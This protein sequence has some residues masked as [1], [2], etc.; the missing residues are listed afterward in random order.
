MRNIEL[1]WLGRAIS[2]CFTKVSP[3]VISINA[4]DFLALIR[5]RGGIHKHFAGHRAGE[6]GG[7]TAPLK[8]KGNKQRKKN[9]SMPTPILYQSLNI[10]AWA[11]HETE[12]ARPV[13]ALQLL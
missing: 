7:G 8:E 3:H 12:Q 11:P 4:Q 2:A 5:G 6:G 13:P 1:E 10:I 9:H